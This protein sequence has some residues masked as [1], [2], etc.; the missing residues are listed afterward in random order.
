MNETDKIGF[1]SSRSPTTRFI[2]RTRV[3]RKC[4]GV[5]LFEKYKNGTHT[6]EAD[7]TIHGG[8]LMMVIFQILVK[9]FQDLYRIFDGW[10][11]VRLE[12]VKYTPIKT[13]DWFFS[14]LGRFGFFFTL[15]F[16][17]FLFSINV[18][19]FCVFMCVLS[20][21]SPIDITLIIAGAGRV[22]NSWELVVSWARPASLVCVYPPFG[23]PL[24][25][26]SPLM[27][28]VRL[29]FSMKEPRKII[30]QNGFR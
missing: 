4:E 30:E 6:I 2:Q 1:L 9:G 10:S 27:S 24:A 18:C 22:D 21:P 15:S 17:S 8:D 23:A 13:N 20:R 7:N 25:C 16:H 29:F 26:T 12:I 14:R 5:F 3:W 28:T 19:F 11:H